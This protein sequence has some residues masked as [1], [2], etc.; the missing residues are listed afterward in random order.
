MKS[1]VEKD[2]YTNVAVA[3]FSA[4]VIAPFLIS[5]FDNTFTVALSVILSFAFLTIAKYYEF[6]NI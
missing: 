5:G 6:K 2:F 1:T 4:G 3:W